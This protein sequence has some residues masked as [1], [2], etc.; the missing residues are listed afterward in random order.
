MPE[1]GC[2]G[3]TAHT[4]AGDG[5]HAGFAP[6]GIPFPKK[7][8]DRGCPHPTHTC[9]CQAGTIPSPREHA[10]M[11]RSHVELVACGPVLHRGVPREEQVL[12]RGVGEPDTPQAHMGL[13][14]G[15]PDPCSMQV[16][17]PR[18]TPR[19]PC[20]QAGHGHGAV[21]PQAVPE[22]SLPR[23]QGCAAVRPGWKFWRM[24]GP[25]HPSR[26]SCPAAG[27]RTPSAWPR[28]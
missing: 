12:R 6:A 15:R 8:R 28:R 26:G 25:P 13:R 21:L 14:Q 11:P 22:Q 10:Q 17:M 23:T 5:A 24:G 2:A 16:V 19:A 27:P 20:S 4:C 3:S 1:A 7:V 9:T 18:V